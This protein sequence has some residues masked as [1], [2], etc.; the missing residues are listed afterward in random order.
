[1]KTTAKRILAALWVAGALA[2]LAAVIFLPGRIEFGG[3]DKATAPATAGLEIIETDVLEAAHGTDPAGVVDDAN[4]T[5]LNYDSDGDGALDA[6]LAKP[7]GTLV[8]IVAHVHT[9]LAD[10]TDPDDDVDFSTTG[11]LRFTTWGCDIDDNGDLDGDCVGND[12]G[13][14]FDGVDASSIT[15]QTVFDVD[16][17]A[18]GLCTV[19]AD[20][21]IDGG[22]F[23]NP[24]AIAIAQVT[25]DSNRDSTITARTII[26]ATTYTDT[27][28]VICAS[29]AAVSVAV[30]DTIT[31]IRR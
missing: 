12:D 10:E 4:A 17:A 9:G 25:C 14:L 20:T 24:D 11:G 8:R 26:G 3:K 13:L 22:A 28:R 6:I 31:Q 21:C 15:T 23:A 29:K 5:P 16:D 30:L 1:M 19:A 7:P 27:I 2:G 18:D